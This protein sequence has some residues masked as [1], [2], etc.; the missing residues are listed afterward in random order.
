[1]ALVKRIILFLLSIILIIIFLIGATTSYAEVTYKSEVTEEHFH[2]YT[3]DWIG[4]NNDS[5]QRL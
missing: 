4:E 3:I 1:V 2:F 5:G